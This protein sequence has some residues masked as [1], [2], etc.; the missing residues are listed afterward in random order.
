MEWQLDQVNL[1]QVTQIRRRY[2]TWS[3]GTR[4]LFH[5]GQKFNPLQQ[6]KYQPGAPL[7][8]DFNSVLD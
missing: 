7:V 5:Q 4:R 2:E 6:S 1:W 8:A 3:Q